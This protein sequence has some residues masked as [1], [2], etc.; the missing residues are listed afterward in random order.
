MPG[1]SRYLG[2]SWDI[3]AC[4]NQW[5]Q[6]RMEVLWTQASFQIKEYAGERQGLSEVLEPIQENSQNPSSLFTHP[7]FKSLLKGGGGGG[8]SM[9]QLK[10]K[11]NSLTQYQSLGSPRDLPNNS[12]LLWPDTFKILWHLLSYL[13]LTKT[14]ESRFIINLILQMGSLRFMVIK[15]L[16]NKQAQ[17]GLEP[18]PTRLQILFIYFLLRLCYILLRYN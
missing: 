7:T 2:E 18:N 3:L 17:L 13:I 9:Q 11:A 5:L 14:V 1:L 8:T 10:P 6:N 15:W 4:Q 16:V 12:T